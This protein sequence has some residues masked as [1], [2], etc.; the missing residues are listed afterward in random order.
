[1]SDE[2]RGLYRKY[3]VERT[4]GSSAPG[5]KHEDC[6]YFVL[7]LE[8]DEFSV[9]ALQAYAAAA[10]SRYPNLARDLFA[11]VGRRS[12]DL[13]DE[14]REALLWMR[15]SVQYDWP[16]SKAVSKPKALAVL[17]KLLARKP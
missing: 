3:K 13:T 8:H 11:M 2:N 7:D 12:A 4:D 5:G 15:N 17:D 1:M 6:R 10:E 16:D 9:P 14:E